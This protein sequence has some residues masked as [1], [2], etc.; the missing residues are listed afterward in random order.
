M[1]K[2]E[3]RRSEEVLTILALQIG[4]F[5]RIQRTYSVPSLRMCQNEGRSIGRANSTSEPVAEGDAR[6]A[7]TLNMDGTCFY[8]MD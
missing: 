1:E 7:L 5:P 4:L 6:I 8:P 2:Q 3:K